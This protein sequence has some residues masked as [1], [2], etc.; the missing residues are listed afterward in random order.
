METVKIKKTVAAPVKQPPTTLTAEGLFTE[1]FWKN[2]GRGSNSA[3]RKA[4]Q[5]VTFTLENGQ[6][7]SQVARAAPG[8]MGGQYT[9][10]LNVPFANLKLDA[11]TLR[12][13]AKTAAK[14]ADVL[15]GLE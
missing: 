6:V 3:A 2:Q 12:N 5:S 9:D 10:L 11:T 7:T 13:I 14:L 15:E 8:E 1:Q 4:K